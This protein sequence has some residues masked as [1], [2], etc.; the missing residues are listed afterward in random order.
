LREEDVKGLASGQY[1]NPNLAD[2][3][4]LPEEPG[5]YD[6]YAEVRGNRS[7]VVTIEILAGA[8]K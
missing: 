2:F 5:T 3:A 4:G 8:G 7:N 6:V 1:F